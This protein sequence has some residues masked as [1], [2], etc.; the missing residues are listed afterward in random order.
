MKL[1]KGSFLLFLLGTGWYT[2]LVA[3]PLLSPAAGVPAA[4]QALR[5]NFENISFDTTGGR[6]TVYY[7]QRL[8]RNPFIGLIEMRQ[9]TT[10][11]TDAPGAPASAGTPGAGTPA[12][13]KN[14]V[15][16]I[17]GIPVGKYSMEGERLEF[18]PL[19]RG[20]R[21]TYYVQRPHRPWR[22]YKLDFW[23]QPQFAAYFGNRNQP[24]ESN[25]YLL[26]MTQLYLSRGLVLNGGVL[27]PLTNDL[28]NRPNIVRPAPLFLNQFLALDGD[29][30]VSASAGFFH[31]DQYG[32][33]V[34]YRHMP[35]SG[36]WSF[37]AETG[38][39]GEFYFTRRGAIY[40]ALDNLLLLADVA[41]RL[42][43]PDLTLKLSGGQYLANDVGARLDIIRQFTNVEVG[44]YTTKS[45][46]GATLGF[47]LAVPIP[48]GKLW[49]GDRARLR[50]GEEFRWEY[51]YTR[52]YNIGERYRTGYQL[53]Q[54]LRQYHRNYLNRQY[55]MLK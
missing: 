22:Q 24:I 43:R 39:T 51:T 48:P 52:G 8:Y 26:L 50:T 23:L 55:Q 2:Q 32:L 20:E 46:N 28:D 25:T 40:G 44:L 31:D 4:Q 21:Q 7:E 41:Y 49:Q 53:D 47:N 5:Q 15:P 38:L 18:S 9:V 54:R 1:S 14:F 6:S 11:S 35:L 17:Q 13:I 42:P 37:G 33:N 30:F 27:F 45:R 19:S 16:L 34:Q 36:A 3:Q 12:V 10:G 29:H